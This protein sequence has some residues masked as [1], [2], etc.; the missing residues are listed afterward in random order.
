MYLTAAYS[1]QQTAKRWPNVTFWKC[2]GS[3]FYKPI[4]NHCKSTYFCQF[5]IS[6][7]R[8]VT[9]LQRDAQLLTAV[10]IIFYFLFFYGNLK[11]SK[12]IK[13]Q[14]RIEPKNSVA[15]LITLDRPASACVNA[16][17]LRI[18][19]ILTYIDVNLKIMIYRVE[20]M[21][22]KVHQTSK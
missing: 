3:S 9:N 18:C 4:E 13:A 19:V 20:T 7:R 11:T 12:I 2:P 5:Y 22:N 10:I 21:C 14:R 8:I 16:G 6:L 1:K 17:S 15:F